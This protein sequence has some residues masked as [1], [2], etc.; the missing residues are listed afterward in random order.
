M[1]LNGVVCE[2]CKDGRFFHCVVHRCHKGGF[3][4]SIIY[5]CESYFNRIL[6]KYDWVKYFICPSKFLLNKHAESGISLKRL[7]HIPNFIKL[8]NFQPSFNVGS[9]V[10][11]AGR[12]SREKGILS[13]LKSI[14]DL[15]IQLKIVGDGPMRNEY[16]RF[17]RENS[18]K[19]VIFEGYKSGDELRDLFRGAAF[20]VFPS[21][22]YENAPM[23]VLEA[24]AYG[25]PVIG[26]DIGGIPEMIINGET[27]FLFSPGDHQ[28]LREK[29]Q[30]LLSNPS[31]IETLGRKAR[32][33]VEEEYNADLHYKRLM[34]IYNNA[35]DKPDP[36]FQ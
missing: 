36:K 11:Y 5:T 24:F 9:Y 34:E 10:L 7:V 29:I 4:P 15:D 31:L 16:E 28:D 17:V 25:K 27:G 21:E 8:D 35:S 19:D 23:T 3:L 12:L 2:K 20:V 13:L 1:L 14:Q 18:L 22:W 30:Y 33:R 26:S 32:K 6:K